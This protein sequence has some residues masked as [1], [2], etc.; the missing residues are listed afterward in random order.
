VAKI[1]RRLIVV[2]DAHA[3]LTPV[4]QNQLS[5]ALAAEETSVD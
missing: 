3:L 2:L 4:E 5:L 1:E